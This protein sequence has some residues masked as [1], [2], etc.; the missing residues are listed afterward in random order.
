MISKLE[1]EKTAAGKKGKG[2]RNDSSNS[3][4]IDPDSFWREMDSSTNRYNTISK[5]YRDMVF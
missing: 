3:K 1:E 4:L 2:G 5:K